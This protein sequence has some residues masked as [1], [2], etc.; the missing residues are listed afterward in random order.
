MDYQKILETVAP[1]GLSCEKCFAF[2]DGEIKAHASALSELLGPNFHEYAKLFVYF[3]PKFENYPAF[4]E[5]LEVLS[6][7]YCR[8]CRADVCLFEGCQ[9]RSCVKEKGVNFCFECEEFPCKTTGMSGQ[10]YEIW[11][12]NNEMMKDLGVEQYY[13]RTK[14]LHRYPSIT[15][16]LRMNSED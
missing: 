3:N 4:R 9:V 7:A 6:K 2:S 5:L 11:K 14:G 12:R 1:C 8:G 13:E 15:E 10:L 16:S